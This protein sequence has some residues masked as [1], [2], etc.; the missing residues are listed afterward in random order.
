MNILYPQILTTCVFYKGEKFG[1]F[2]GEK[3]LPS[4]LDES[5]DTRLMWEVIL[6]QTTYTPLTLQSQH[7]MFLLISTINGC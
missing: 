7:S 3:K 1:P 5:T 2:A 4:E 6:K